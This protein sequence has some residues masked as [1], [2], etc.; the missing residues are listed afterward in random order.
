MTQ[1]DVLMMR[2]DNVQATIKRVITDD[3]S[4]A[5]RIIEIKHGSHWKVLAVEEV[6]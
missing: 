6:K 5:Q 1:Y 3:P 2:K 4:K